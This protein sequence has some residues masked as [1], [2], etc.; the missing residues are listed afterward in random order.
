MHRMTMLRSEPFDPIV[1]PPSARRRRRP[2][3]TV[4][5][6]VRSSP[7]DHPQPSPAS[8]TRTDDGARDRERHDPK[9]EAR[10]RIRDATR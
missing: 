2:S 9:D 5:E 7:S 8:A 3:V 1:A 4:L 10:D 6:A